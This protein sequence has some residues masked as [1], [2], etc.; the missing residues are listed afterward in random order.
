MKMQKPTSLFLTGFLLSVQWLSALPT[1]PGDST[2][3]PNLA[4]YN[5]KD[6]PYAAR[7]DSLMMLRIFA[8]DSTRTAGTEMGAP[9]TAFPAAS[10]VSDSVYR[11]R[12]AYMNRRTPLRYTYNETVRAFIELYADRKRDQVE[13]MMGLA[14]Y[15]FPLFESVL[16]RYNMP[17]EIKYLAVVESALNPNARSWA[18]AQGLWQFMYGTARMNGLEVSSY[19]DERNDPLK[20]TVAACEYLTKLYGIFDDWNLALAAYNS[21]PGNVSQAIRYSGGKRSYWEIRPWLPRETAS[22]VPA[23]IAASYV[24]QYAEAHGLQAREL[25]PSF[26][27]TDTVHIKKQVSLDQLAA[28]LDVS[29][30]EL[31]FLNPAYR[32]GM[33]PGIPEDPHTLTLPREAIGRFKL[34]EDSIYTIAAAHF[35]MD[36]KQEPRYVELGNRTYHRVR[37]GEVLGTIAERYGVRVSSLRRWN[38]IRGNLIRVGQRLKVYPQKLPPKTASSEPAEPQPKEKKDA[39]PQPSGKAVYHRVRSGESFYSIA[40]KFPGISADNIME[41]NNF[42]DARDLKPG[43]R[44]KIYPDK[45]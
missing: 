4:G 37:R 33:I 2:K 29:R 27:H 19:I 42:S 18:G 17:L 13:R 34:Y 28:L 10:A 40:R 36:Q 30:E 6:L 15:Y 21:G 5:L 25:K 20:S 41:W 11:Q 39:A 12:L 16:D 3:K 45:A 32:Y 26:F 24:F 9:D 14:H 35:Q 8:G 44:L 22:Y 31:A 43:D 7:L 1:T 38:G 23:F